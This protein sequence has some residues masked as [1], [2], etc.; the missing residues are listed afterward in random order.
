MIINC[1]VKCNLIHPPPQKKIN[2]KQNRKQEQNNDLASQEK[3]Q[4]AYVYS[5]GFRDLQLGQ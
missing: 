1:F 3:K 4:R 2:Y 5:L